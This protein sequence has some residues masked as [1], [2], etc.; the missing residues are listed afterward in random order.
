MMMWFAWVTGRQAVRDR[1][2]RESLVT[3]AWG[4][5]DSTSGYI[6]GGDEKDNVAATWRLWSVEARF[7]SREGLHGE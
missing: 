2:G 5:R 4:G 6:D 1:F 7:G 3:A